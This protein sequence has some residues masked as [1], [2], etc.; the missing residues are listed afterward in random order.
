LNFTLA[1]LAGL[2]LLLPGIAALAAWNLA[3][4][5]DGARRQEFQLTSPTALFGAIVVALCAHGVGYGLLQLSYAAAVEIGGLTSASTPLWPDPYL[6]V[7]EVA[8]QR[9]PAGS[10][11]PSLFSALAGF[12][13]VVCIEAA[14]AFVFVGHEAVELVTDG[15]DLR[16]QGWGYQ[17]IV[18]PIRHGYTPIAYVHTTSMIGDHGVGFSGVVADA[19]QGSDGELKVLSLGRPYRFLFK[20]H[21]AGPFRP[22]PEMEIFEEQWEGGTV[23][24]E[25]SKIQSVI[26]H[27][28][29]ADTIDDL[30]DEDDAA[31]SDAAV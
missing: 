6:V 8:S 21:P 1:L 13:V 9:I 19:R 26:I 25:P 12:V 30:A 15:L 29:R 7:F 23:V 2:V 17:T 5:R 24:L 27:A 10:L 22:A 14:A 16:S 3:G 4:A 31:L 28:V 18:R 20:V 11:D